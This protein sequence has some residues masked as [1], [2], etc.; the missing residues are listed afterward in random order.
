[1]LK[2]R[3]L[4]VKIE[5]KEIL[6]GVDL[7][8]KKGEVVALMGPNGSGKSS[9]ANTLIGNT[10]YEAEAEELSFEGICLLELKPDARARLGIMMSFQYPV[11]ISGVT[12]REMLLASLRGRGL[13]V[14][15]LDLKKQIAEEGERLHIDEHLLTRSINEGFSGGEKKKLEILQMRILKP[16]LLILDE[17]DSGLDIDALALIAKNV[18]EMVKAG[19][20]VLVI[21]HYQRLLKYLV[22]DRVVVMKNGEVVDRGGK[23]IVDKLEA[24]GYKSYE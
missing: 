5:G 10:K 18:V 13:T 19:M 20:S 8:V 23:E 16:K 3:N 7:E 1:M 9:L 14:S 17:V 4:K 21:T 22:P 6:K 24:Q 11:A 2:I 15:A 12:V